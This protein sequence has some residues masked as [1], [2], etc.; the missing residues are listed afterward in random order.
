MKPVHTIPSSPTREESAATLRT[1]YSV[2]YL[3]PGS[4]PLLEELVSQRGVLLVDIRTIAGS[5]Y[6]PAFSAKRLR[7]RFGAAY[8]RLRALGNCNFQ[9]PE[10]PIVLRNPEQGVAQL[11]T[12]L[13]QQDVCLL[14]RCQHL[15][16]CHTAVL[17]DV[18]AQ[19]CPSLHVVRL[20][21]QEYPQGKET[22][23]S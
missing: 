6:R 4:L 1:L 11:R 3:N 10:A 2:G 18:L 15:T 23:H 17:L 19:Q 16:L 12:F 20:G 21:E 9:Q 14:C 5:R 13:D 22:L 8:T 7:E